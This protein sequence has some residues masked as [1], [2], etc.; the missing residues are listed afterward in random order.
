M[1]QP[2]HHTTAITIHFTALPKIPPNLT[3]QSYILNDT[4]KQVIIIP[5]TVT[6]NGYITE[7][8]TKV[9]S[10]MIAPPNKS[11]AKVAM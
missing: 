6:R 7:E 5:T 2:S 11:E 9:F 1:L 4:P 3:P 10:T 8:H